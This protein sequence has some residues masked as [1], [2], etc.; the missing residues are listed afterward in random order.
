MATPYL[1]ENVCFWITI[2]RMKIQTDHWQKMI[3]ENNGREM[4]FG[5]DFNITPKM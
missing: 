5:G 2:K 3:D 1:L 4:I